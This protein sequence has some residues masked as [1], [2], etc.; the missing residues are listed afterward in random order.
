MR[1]GF[2]SYAVRLM[3]DVYFLEWT[4]SDGAVVVRGEG[5]V[6]DLSWYGDSEV[7]LSLGD[8]FHSRRLG[9]RASQ[10]GTISPARG[11]ASVSSSDG[12]FGIGITPDVLP[13]LFNAFEQGEEQVDRQGP[14]RRQ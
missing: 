4:V 8:A 9:I 14:R 13:R 12:T 11:G 2:T 1:F 7:Q 6:V 3:Q 5:T 10:V